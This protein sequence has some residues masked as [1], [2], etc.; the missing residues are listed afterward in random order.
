[1]VRVLS[2]DDVAEVLDL[3]DLLPVVAEAFR[4]QG[5]GEVER[6][7]RPHFPVGEGLSTEAPEEP[8]GT[9]LVMPAY[10]HG[11][12]HYATKLVAV[13]EGNAERG[14][15]TVNA[16]I[17]LT[18]AGTGL[19]AAYLAGTRITNARTGCI[20]GLAARELATGPVSLGLVGAGTQARW[21]A[22]AVDAATDLRS[23]RVYSPSDSR[24]ACAAELRDELGVDAEA[25][26]S[27][28]AA[29]EGA[30]VV[31]TATTATEPT[32]PGEAL[33]PGAV[34]VAVGAYTAEMQEL[35]PTTFERA[36]T[37]FADVPAEVAETGDALAAGLD[38]EDMVPLSAV[39]SGG[40]GREGE[41]DILVVESVGTA[42]LDAAAAGYV[43]EAA[44]ERGVGTEV[45]L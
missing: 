10:I 14:V 17:A 12:D 34:V 45:G 30:N 18:Q 44:E 21:Q 41:H 9:G 8:M 25:V 1:M 33:A 26:D 24:E 3:E 42:V 7:E 2:D 23:V 38:A 31:V 11:E 6:P 28:T 22:R 5:A 37:V 40:A 19:P 36:G 15:P 16:Q 29:V 27:P 20:G 43:V 13:H 35:D 4:K 32:F 39:L